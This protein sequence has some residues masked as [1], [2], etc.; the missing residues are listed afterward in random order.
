ME[1][2]SGQA[3]NQNATGFTFFQQ[4]MLSLNVACATGYAV[5]LYVVRSIGSWMPK[6]NFFYFFLRS[7]YR[8]NDLLGVHSRSAVSTTQVARHSSLLWGQP[9]S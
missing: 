9:G 2:Q 7:A 6:N 1:D 3:R 4:L 8:I 5:V